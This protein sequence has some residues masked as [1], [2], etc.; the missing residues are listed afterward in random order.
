MQRKTARE[1]NWLN[2]SRKNRLKYLEALKDLYRDVK[3]ETD[4]EGM[5][6]RGLRTDKIRG[7]ADKE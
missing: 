6:D 3:H 4:K 5:P 2:L 7:V 1:F